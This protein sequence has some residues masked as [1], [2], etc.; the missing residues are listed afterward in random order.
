MLVAL[1]QAIGPAART[2]GVQSLMNGLH[3]A[4]GDEGPGG[5]GY[6]VLF[7][8]AYCSRA[9]AGV[10]ATVVARIIASA[11]RHNPA[12]GITGL[13]VYGGGLF[14][15]WIEGPRDSIEGLLATLRKDDRHDTLVV[16]STSEEARERLFPG[17]DM[18]R[19]SAADVRDVLL[20]A[21]A[22][23]QDPKNAQA[24]RGLLAQLDTVALAPLKPA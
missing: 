17:W 10:D 1:Q 7:Q 16:L 9:A 4:G 20:D 14:F 22:D 6:P 18:E 3:V 24:L 23:V 13:L 21:L 19:V 2:S 5:R 15:Q 8:L 12:L 11:R